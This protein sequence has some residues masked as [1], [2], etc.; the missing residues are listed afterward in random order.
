MREVRRQEIHALYQA[1]AA[2]KTPFSK[3]TQMRELHCSTYSGASFNWHED[4]IIAYKAY[5][6]AQRLEK[7]WKALTLSDQKHQVLRALIL[8]TFPRHLSK[9]TNILQKSST[10]ERPTTACTKPTLGASPVAPRG[11]NPLS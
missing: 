3:A 11:G 4:I 9:E 2:I 6:Y 1:K 8:T 10:N 7:A 5:R